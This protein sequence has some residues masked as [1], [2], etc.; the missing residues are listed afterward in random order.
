MNDEWTIWTI[1]KDHQRII[2]DRSR[3]LQN[4]K[5]AIGMRMCTYVFSIATPVP[6]QI[7]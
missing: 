3:A 2:A 6:Y 7:F 1:Q 4:A 5:R